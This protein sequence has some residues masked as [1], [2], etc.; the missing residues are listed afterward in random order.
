M[1]RDT[2]SCC[3]AKRECCVQSPVF[4]RILLEGCFPHRHRFHADTFMGTTHRRF[5]L[6]PGLGTVLPIQISLAFAK[7]YAQ[8]TLGIHIDITGEL[9]GHAVNERMWQHIVKVV[10]IDCLPS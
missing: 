6:M 3:Y 8:D 5:L 9:F 4:G 10:M 2:K 7:L 1:D